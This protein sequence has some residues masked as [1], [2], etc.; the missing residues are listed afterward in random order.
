MDKCETQALISTVILFPF[1]NSNNEVIRILDSGERGI[2][3]G[4]KFQINYTIN[5]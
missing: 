2:Y 3:Y 5:Y 1:G 4:L